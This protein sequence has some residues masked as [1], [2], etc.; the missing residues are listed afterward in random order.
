MAVPIC[1]QPLAGYWAEHQVG[2]EEPA[3]QSGGAVQAG[4]VIAEDS[5]RRPRL[6]GEA[7]DAQPASEVEHP[8]PERGLHPAGG[9]QRPAGLLSI[10]GVRPDGLRRYSVC[11][12][13]TRRVNARPG[14]TRPAAELEERSLIQAACGAAQRPLWPAGEYTSGPLR[15]HRTAYLPLLAPESWRDSGSGAAGS[16][17]RAVLARWAMPAR[18]PST[19]GAA[20]RLSSASR[21][22][23][24]KRDW[25][26][27][28]RWPCA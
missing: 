13:P 27:K 15:R 11:Q 9:G 19:C 1:S 17:L 8:R 26:T 4:T 3:R 16:R 2:A 22:S 18:P 14:A 5:S 24:T 28:S 10:R 7:N 20:S 23:L 21:P 25:N 12:T 6:Q